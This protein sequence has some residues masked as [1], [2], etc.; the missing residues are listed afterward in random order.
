MLI[1]V[2]TVYFYLAG[3]RRLK[4]SLLRMCLGRDVRQIADTFFQ[5]LEGRIAAYFGVV[6][7][8]NLFVGLFVTALAWVAALP[9]ADLRCS[10]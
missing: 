6:T 7:V 4:A 2:A 10:R 1:F 9:G 5:E 3:R 8:I